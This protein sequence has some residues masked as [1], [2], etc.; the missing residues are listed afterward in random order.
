LSNTK[1]RRNRKDQVIFLAIF[2]L[3]LS[4][5]TRP[6]SA[7]TL[8]TAKSV[9]KPPTEMSRTNSTEG[10][11]TPSKVP[12]AQPDS[13]KDDRASGTNVEDRV[14]AL[15]DELRAQ[16][17]RLV[18]MSKRIAD[19]QRTIEHLS[20]GPPRSA[21]D[22]AQP[23]NP[24]TPTT[25]LA[26]NKGAATPQKADTEEPAPL[27]FRIGSA[28]ITPVGFLDFTA[29]YRSTNGGSG[30][31]TNFGSIPFSNTT[32][33]NLSEVRLSA[34][35]AR[36][37][38]RVDAKVHG[39]NVIG[40]FESDFLGNNPG[41]VSVSSNS[42]T[43]RLRLYWADVRKGKLEFLGGQSWSMMT[44]GRK[45]ISP[46]PGDLFYSQNIDVNYQ[47]G[48]VWARQPQF[49]IV[50]HPSSRWTMGVSFENPEQYIGGS[51][52]G[53]A[54]TLP[55]GLAAS[56]GTELNNGGNTLAVPNLLPD[57]V[58]KI[59]FDSKLGTHDLHVEGAGLVRGFKVFNPVTSQHFSST[60]GGGSINVNLEVIKNVRLVSNNFFSDGGGRYIF[61]QAPDLIARGDG[62]LSLVHA[63]STVTGFEATV[64]KN[65]LLYGYYGGVYI[66]RNVTVDPLTGKLV[67]YGYS[68]SPAGQNRSVQEVTL[69]FT[70]TFWRDPKYGALQF[71]GQYSYLVRN[72]WFVAA[73]GLKDAHTNMIFLNLRY[74]L[75]GKA[76][77]PK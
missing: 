39:A 20:S 50:Y 32:Q 62:S 69:G 30:I 27:S 41:N 76:P 34:Q 44:P 45:G 3:T 66:G 43:N 25:P 5:T 73:G 64:K 49:R 75:P 7:Q 70:Q 22:A 63:Y 61:G 35:N 6:A 58:G 31:G 47:A 59:A 29:V 1:Q 54:I 17:E 53:G 57:V 37:G 48:L 77:S 67:G 19:Q 60:G 55:T 18:E 51:A 56:Y 28:S 40:Y 9:V 46:I 23:I 13:K 68:G 74:L 8:V 11:K 14:K 42:D 36:I 26:S 72:P 21:A 65:T 4:A 38:F 12:A 16:N 24:S 2:L 10:G 33:G 15:E 71:M 52:G